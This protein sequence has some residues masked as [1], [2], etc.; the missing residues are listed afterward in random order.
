MKPSILRSIAFIIAVC[1]Q[2]THSLIVQISMMKAGTHLGI[3]LLEKMTGK[4]MAFIGPHSYAKMLEGKQ[5]VINIS[6][7]DFRKQSNLPESRFWINHSP[8]V[9]EYA[10]VL[11]DPHYQVMFLYRDPRDIVV[12][13]ALYIR[14]KD[15]EFWPGAQNISLEETITRLIVGGESMHITDHHI[16]K[17]GIKKMYDAYLPWMKFPNIL[18]IR[19]ED[20]VGPRG[21]GNREAQVRT[22]T[23]ISHHIGQQISYDDAVSYGESIFGTSTLFNK[24]QIGSWKTYFTPRH[25]KLFKEHAGQLLIDLGYEHD[26]DWNGKK[27]L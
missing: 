22:I 6:P 20:L 3:V 27:P 16:S 4:R 8:Y 5:D 2:T 18:L 7:K 19:F 21:G 15:K 23:A 11:S 26:L 14:S 1:T 13:L 12:S 17:L 10:E 25:I 24:G 9:E